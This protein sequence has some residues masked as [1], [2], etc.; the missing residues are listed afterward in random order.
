MSE[1]V[2]LRH[3]TD[4][5]TIVMYIFEVLAPAT[6]QAPTAIKDEPIYKEKVSNIKN[7]K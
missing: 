4:D 6:K 3:V 5:D 7:N 2:S 1:V